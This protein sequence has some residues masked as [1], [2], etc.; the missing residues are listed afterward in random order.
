MV[1]I[2]MRGSLILFLWWVLSEM[3]NIEKMVKIRGEECD[4]NRSLG[5]SHEEG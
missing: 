5:G 2:Y 1:W 4:L 3:Y